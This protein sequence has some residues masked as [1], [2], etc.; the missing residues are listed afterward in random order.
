VRTLNLALRHG[1]IDRA[2]AALATRG[3][4]TSPPLTLLEAEVL[5]MVSLGLDP[6]RGCA[7]VGSRRVS[8]AMSRLRR[9][10][11]VNYGMLPGEKDWPSPAGDAALLETFRWALARGIHP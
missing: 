9:K 4:P 11:F 2:A 3:A 8:Q 5:A 10:A 6:W 7:G 1:V